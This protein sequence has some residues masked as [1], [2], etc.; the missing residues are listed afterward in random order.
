MILEFAL[1]SEPDYSNVS[2]AE[3]AP[4]GE[5]GFTA[6]E[7]ERVNGAIAVVE[8][9]AMAHPFAEAVEGGNGDFR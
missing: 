1:L 9:S 3:I 7:R 2:R 6:R 4:S 8:L 5:H